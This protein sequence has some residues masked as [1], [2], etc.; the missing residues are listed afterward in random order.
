MQLQTQTLFSW[1]R[2]RAAASNQGSGLAQDRHEKAGGTVETWRLEPKIL[3]CESSE[4]NTS[5]RE[6]SSSGR[7]TKFHRKQRGMVC[8]CFV[9]N[10][11]WAAG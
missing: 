11:D 1:E 10:N 9:S 7:G 5:S 6:I 2:V 8:V 4:E 3:G